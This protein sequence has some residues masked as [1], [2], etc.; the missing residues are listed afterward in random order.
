MDNEVKDCSNC[1]HCF[2]NRY[3]TLVDEIIPYGSCSFW[4][5]D[6]HKEVLWVRV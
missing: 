2:N 1:L 3:C 4:Q 6:E 5:R